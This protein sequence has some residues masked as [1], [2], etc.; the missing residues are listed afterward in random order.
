[1]PTTIP[2]DHRQ[3]RRLV[4]RYVAAFPTRSDAF[5]FYGAVSSIAWQRETVEVL[6]SGF[7]IEE[8]GDGLHVLTLTFS[9]GPV[10]GGHLTDGKRI[11]DRARAVKQ[12]VEEEPLTIIDRT[13]E[14]V[15]A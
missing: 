4:F 3:R 2:P 12:A 8:R 11:I 13:A 15:S 14:P 5:Q 9:Y 10:I 1:M 7:D 6:S